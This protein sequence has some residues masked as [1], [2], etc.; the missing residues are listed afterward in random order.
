[1][2]AGQANHPS[3][4]YRLTVNPNN[5]TIRLCGLSSVIGSRVLRSLQ[6][7]KSTLIIWRRSS[8]HNWFVENKKGKILWH[9]GEGLQ[10]VLPN[11]SMFKLIRNSSRRIW[12]GNSF[13]VGSDEGVPELS[14]YRLKKRY[15]Y[16]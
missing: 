10:R 15:R 8:P 6:L 9:S 2:P 5:R 1:M 16:Y 12:T 14:K 4:S 13:V 11:L 3:R 7:G